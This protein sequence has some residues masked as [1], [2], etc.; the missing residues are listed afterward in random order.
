MTPD[1]VMAER[2]TSRKRAA[3]ERPDAWFTEKFH[4]RR[5]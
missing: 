4:T 5:I 1:C 2:R 3:L